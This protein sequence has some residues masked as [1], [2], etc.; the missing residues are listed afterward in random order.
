[1]VN[2]THFFRDI[3]R[4]KYSTSIVKLA[5]SCLTGSSRFVSFNSLILYCPLEVDLWTTTLMAE[6]NGGLQRNTH[7]CVL[8][9]RCSRDS[10][11]VSMLWAKSKRLSVK[12]SKRHTFCGASLFRPQIKASSSERGPL[13]V[14]FLCWNFPKTAILKK[15][16]KTIQANF[17]TIGLCK[18]SEIE[19][20]EC[21]GIDTV[22]QV[23]RGERWWKSC[24]GW[25]GIVDQR[26]SSVFKH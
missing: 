7:F 1:M 22:G 14:G 21:C 11:P 6:E 18:Q 17:I 3:T 9:L 8:N 2:L 24:L 25:T 15:K 10:R 13:H 12:K 5:L 19:S 4:P 26:H 23:S 20:G 16:N